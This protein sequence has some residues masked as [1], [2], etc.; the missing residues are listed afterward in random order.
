VLP[1][2]C[3]Y[4]Q[5]AAA[6]IPTFGRPG[7]RAVN[8]VGHARFTYEPQRPSVATLAPRL[9]HPRQRT[10]PWGGNPRISDWQRRHRAR[11]P[12]LPNNNKIPASQE[13]QPRPLDK[14]HAI[15]GV[16]AEHPALL[17]LAIWC[18]LEAESC[19]AIQYHG[20]QRMKL[21]RNA[22]LSVKAPR[23]AGR[24]CRERRR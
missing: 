11:R 2:G 18:K 6:D 19:Q 10:R 8:A 4:S 24:S 15:S 20:E 13:N 16:D 21:H 14:R 23:A 3:R 17:K 12:A 7:R 1:L 22:R 5:L 9:A